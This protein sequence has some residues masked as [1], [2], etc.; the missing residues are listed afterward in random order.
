MSAKS[1]FASA[2]QGFS[3][4]LRKPTRPAPAPLPCAVRIVAGMHRGAMMRLRDPVRLG[5]HD[6]SD[7]VLRDSDVRP[8]HA[9]LRRVDGIWGLYDLHDGSVMPAFKT[10]RRGRFVRQRHA[11]GSAQLVVTQS[12]PYVAPRPPMRK[13]V[14]KVLAPMALVAALSICA[15]VTVQ[16]VTPASARVVTG[17]RTLAGEG[18][19]DV[20]LVTT[21]NA[22][23]LV[24]GFVDDAATLD[25][26][27]R[28]LSEQHM[29]QVM[30]TVRVGSEL[31]ARVSEALAEPELQVAYQA[32]GKVLVHGTSTKMTVRSHL[33]R[34]A[35]DLAG[36]VRLDD[37]VVYIEE[38][39]NTPKAYVLP[40]R[41]TDAR[42]GNDESGGS[43]GTDTGAR[44]FVG[45]TLP[46]GSEVVAVHE[47]NIEFSLAG[48]R[49]NYP[50]K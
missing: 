25:K 9:E 44:Y 8:N 29:G 19:P 30:V 32:G 12:I 45:A 39:D 31:V 17:I 47:D 23:P 37:R 36:V 26:L 50:L 33:R 27:Q 21:S 49:I 14:A 18:F 4:R 48:H 10:E 6:G 20:E 7:L 35:S 38:I 24:R 1:N 43:F 3:S 5:S 41:I 34:L 13:L 42:P 15:I 46:D 22:A 11:I 2:T 28:W 16:L 40:M